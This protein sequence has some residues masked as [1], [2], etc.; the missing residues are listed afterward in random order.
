MERCASD[1]PDADLVAAIRRSDETSFKTFYYRYYEIMFN[2]LSRR[3]RNY[4]ASKDLAQELFIRVWK[5]RET[6]DPKQSIKAYVYRIANNLAIDH[7]RKKDRDQATF[8]QELTHEPGIA[9]DETFDLEE[10]V[11]AAICGLPE[12]LQTVY[13]LSRDEELTYPEIA[14]SLEVSVKTVEYR[15]SQALKILREKLKPVL[16]TMLWYF[17]M[18][19]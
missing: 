5:N 4:E 1:A 3:T 11:Q 8:V 18:N 19:F 7:L 6:L 15:M 14:A 17:F 2:F 9:P 16:L 12:P 13:T 10:K